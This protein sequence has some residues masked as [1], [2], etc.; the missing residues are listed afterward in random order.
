MLSFISESPGPAVPDSTYT[1]RTYQ[2]DGGV[3][4]CARLH[5]ALGEASAPCRATT[6]P[7][8]LASQPKGPHLVEASAAAVPDRALVLAVTKRMLYGEETPLVGVGL[9]YKP[10]YI[11]TEPF[12]A[13]YMHLHVWHAVGSSVESASKLS[14]SHLIF[15]TVS[16][17]NNVMPV[18]AQHPILLDVATK[19]TMT[20]T[21]EPMA[22]LSFRGSRLHT[23]WTQP[24]GGDLIRQV[25][26]PHLLGEA[27]TSMLEYEQE[28][29][30]QSLMQGPKMAINLR[31]PSSDHWNI[32]SDLV[33]PLTVDMYRQQHEA[34]RVEQDPEGESAG[35]EG[36]PKEAPAPGK[37]PQVVVGGSK[38]VFPT[39]TTHQGERVL[40]TTLDILKHIHAIRFQTMHDM[41]GMRELEQTLV[42][43]LMAEFARLQLILGEDLAKSLSALCSELETSSEALLSD[44]VSVLNLHSGDLAFPRVKELIQKHQQSISMKVNLPLM[45]L[46]AAREDLGGFLQRCLR[47]LSSHSKS[48]EMIEELSWTLSTHANRIQEAIQAPGIQEPAVFQRVMLGLAMDQPL[49]A[50]FFPGILDRLSGRLGLMPPGVVDPP[51]SARAGV[52]RRWAATLREA[53]MRTEGRDV[54][55]EQVTPHVVH[56]GLHQDYDLDFRMQRVDDIAPTLTSPMLSGLVS[57]VHF[58][59]KPEVPRGPA[60]PKMEEGLWGC[61]GAPAGPDAPGPSCIGGSVPPV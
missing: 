5:P 17:M 57:S 54:N 6:K 14:S 34:K 53:V 42:C 26:F 7:P 44:L 8:G 55:L 36:S 23:V 32:V 47:E 19:D 40:E 31:P 25:A 29:F 58:L 20:R 45:E 30:P 1:G 49:K 27:T 28:K 41:G 2:L 52:S 24:S 46:E 61:S 9:V 35:A 12:S 39:E 48:R 51:T 10:H 21:G 56:P 38:A 43:T 22:P 37:A 13:A 33:L 4:W 11:S 3:P 18:A 50:I 60:S 15:V 16:E 59:G